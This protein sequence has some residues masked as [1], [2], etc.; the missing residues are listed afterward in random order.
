M[1]SGVHARI[2]DSVID[3]VVDRDSYKVGDTAKLL[4]PS[5]FQGE[6]QAL[7]TVERGSI[8]Q[9]E[10]LT[11]TSNSYIYELPITAQFAP[12]V[13][14]SVV[15]IK[16]ID[17]TNSITTLRY[18]LVELTVDNASNMIQLAI[19]ADPPN[20]EP[21]SEVTYTLQTRRLDTGDP[22]SAQVG[23]SLTDLAS[24]SVADDNS[25]AIV[26]YFYGVQPLGVRTSSPLTANIEAIE[27]ALAQ[28]T[29]E[30]AFA[31]ARGGVGGAG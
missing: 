8:F 23:V 12:N 16:G 19:Q 9:T 20:S 7:V 6:T 22:V 29:E 25:Q 30:S 5:P 11:L 27:T 10:L 2:I 17:D 26:D 4:I 14:V 3:L 28:S 21:R 24:L 18:G 15:L 1:L 13:F 31:F